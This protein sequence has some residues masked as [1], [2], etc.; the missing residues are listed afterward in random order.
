MGKNVLEL[1]F[2]REIGH[3]EGCP[4]GGNRAVIDLH[5][6][7]KSIRETVIISNPVNLIDELRF[8]LGTSLT[9]ITESGIRRILEV[10]DF[11]SKIHETHSPALRHSHSWGCD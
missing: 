4:V 5:Y 6:S 1:F 2:F 11:K 8:E 3:S 7:L 10:A 9:P